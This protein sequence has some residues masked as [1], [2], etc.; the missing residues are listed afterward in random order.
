MSKDAH[1]QKD[2]PRDLMLLYLALLKMGEMFSI[3][4]EARKRAWRSSR[5]AS[6]PKI[7]G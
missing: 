4:I 2:V 7:N 3:Y 5:P 6:H 1:I